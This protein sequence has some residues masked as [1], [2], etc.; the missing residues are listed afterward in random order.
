MG[1]DSKEKL[2]N[3]CL[4]GIRCGTKTKT[5]KKKK[6]K[7]YEPAMTTTKLPLVGWLVFW[8]ELD[9]LFFFFVSLISFPCGQFLRGKS[10][11][12][13]GNL[14]FHGQFPCLNFRSC[15]DNDIC[16]MTE[17]VHHCMI[18][19][20]DI[21]GTPYLFVLLSKSKLTLQTVLQW[22]AEQS[23][24]F[25]IGWHQFYDCWT[26]TV[27][28]IHNTDK[29]CHFYTHQACFSHVLR[30]YRLTVVMYMWS[31]LHVEWR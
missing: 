23:Q 26:L 16:N 21:F 5:L 9:F 31:W 19:F 12:L 7:N 2:G 29:T 13:C 10:V 14:H 30:H 15:N 11:S 1:I 17:T 25:A 3:P 22:H 28:L 8:I 18:T 6:K 20:A 24:D 27:S 4:A